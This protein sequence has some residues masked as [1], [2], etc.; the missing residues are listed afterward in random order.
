MTT[1]E[2]NPTVEAAK[3][4]EKLRKALEPATY[5]LSEPITTHNGPVRVLTVRPPK[6]RSFMK[7]MPFVIE[8]SVTEDG[9]A[10]FKTVFNTRVCFQFLSDMTG[11]DEM[12]LA[13]IPGQD[14]MPLFRMIVDYTLGR[15]P[16]SNA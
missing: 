2:T 9:S 12:D 3:A 13:D 7:G 4:A 16:K 6:G 11:I 5:A 15:P 14:V 8:E 10:A 1:T